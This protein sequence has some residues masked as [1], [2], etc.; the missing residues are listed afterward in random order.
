MGDVLAA[1]MKRLRYFAK[2]SKINELVEVASTRNLGTARLSGLLRRPPLRPEKAR[3]GLSRAY[4]S[5]TAPVI[6]ET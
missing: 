6:D 4:Y 5:F 2:S 1:W 3:G